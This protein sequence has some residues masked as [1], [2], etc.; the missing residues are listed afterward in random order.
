MNK[1]KLLILFFLFPISLLAENRWVGNGSVMSSYEHLATDKDHKKGP[2][3]FGVEKD[4]TW[5]HDIPENNIGFFQWFINSRSCEKLKIYSSSNNQKVSITVGAWNFRSEDRTFKNVTLPFVIGKNNVDKPTW[6]DDDQWLVVA[7]KLLDNPAGSEG[8][9]AKCTSE[10]VTNASYESYTIPIMLGEYQWNGTAS[11]ISGYFKSQYNNWDNPTAGNNPRAQW[12]FGIFKDVSTF[13]SK[14][15]K[16]VVFFQWQKS[17]VCPALK[18]DIIGASPDE[19]R[20]RL[21]YKGWKDHPNNVND[22]HTKLPT[23]IKSDEPWTVIGL[24]SD[25]KFSKDYT[26]EAQ[27]Y[28]LC[29]GDIKNITDE[30]YSCY[31]DIK[32]DDTDQYSFTMNIVSIPNTNRYKLKPLFKKMTSFLNYGGLEKSS[33]K[34][35]AKYEETTT[36]N[37]I[38]AAVNGW[39]FEDNDF[40][41]CSNNI[42][43]P[44]KTLISSGD[45]IRKSTQEAV[46]FEKNGKLDFAFNKSTDKTFYNEYLQYFSHSYYDNDSD[47]GYGSDEVSLDWAFGTDGLFLENGKCRDGTGGLPNYMDNDPGDGP[48]KMT[49]LAYNDQKILLIGTTGEDVR[50]FNDVC[51]FLEKQG[52]KYATS[53]D[54]G[55]ASSLII[56]RN[57]NHY[58]INSPLACNGEDNGR[59]IGYGLGFID[60]KAE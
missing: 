54:G 56:K 17:H 29:D 49:I 21:V 43:F 22:R 34:E 2:Y 19:K 31:K 26:V 53:L 60:T 23:I 27:C 5:L 55:S 32:I 18:L 24:Y 36:D 58:Y 45:L 20:V 14:P 50:K 15:N 41:K 42:A 12:P 10:S 4:M 47:S 48:E 35:L 46:F 13:S 57:N 33:L 8:L 1:Y 44:V 40:R 39:T 51:R 52:M 25:Q 37:S 9:Y 3:P 16:Q 38:I 11:I 6:F 59:R 30:A 28:T 7:I